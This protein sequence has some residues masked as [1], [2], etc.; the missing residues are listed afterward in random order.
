M[1]FSTVGEIVLLVNRM[2]SSNR[3]MLIS[4][5]NLRGVNELTDF[6]FLW[7]GI[8]TSKHLDTSCG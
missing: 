4:K 5:G 7:Q 2:L 8:L 6:H 1:K 3:R